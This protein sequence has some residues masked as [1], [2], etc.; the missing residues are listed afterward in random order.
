M[1]PTNTSR[2]RSVRVPCSVRP[3]SP[4]AHV[5]GSVRLAPGGF[6]PRASIFVA[7]RTTTR[8]AAALVTTGIAAPSLVGVSSARGGRRRPEGSAYVTSNADAGHPPHPPL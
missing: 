4:R 5:Y 6:T 3:N 7:H 8:W 2:H 1:N